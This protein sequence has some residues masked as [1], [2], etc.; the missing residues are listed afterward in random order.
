VAVLALIAS[1]TWLRRAP[2]CA[3]GRPATSSS[4][5]GFGTTPRG[6]VD[7]VHYG[8]LGF[9]SSGRGKEWWAVDLE[10]PH[11]V[12]RVVVYGRASCCFEQSVPL[13]LDVS[14]DGNQ[15]RELARRDEPFSQFDP[16]EIPAHDVVTR[17]V[18]L[19]TVRDTVLV[20]GEVDVYA[21]PR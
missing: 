10:R 8:W 13:A 17:F 12:E 9:H 14:L 18:R 3:L 19:R 6:A 15:Y 16:W 5:G 2:N 4:A 1:L 21:R 11:A 7:G 20:L